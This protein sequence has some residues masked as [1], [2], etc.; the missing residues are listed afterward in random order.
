MDKKNFLFVSLDNLSGDLAWH[1]KKEGHEV[2][3]YVKCKTERDVASG[4]I[5]FVDD[6]KPHIDWADVII[7]DDVLGLG[8]IA[9]KLRKRGKKVVGGNAYTDRLEEDRSF[10]TEEM[11]RKGIKIIPYKDF[12]SFDDAIEFIKE[13]P[14]AYV[15]K[16]TGEYKPTALGILYIGYHPKGDDVIDVL[17]NT[18]SGKIKYLASSFKKRLKELR[19]L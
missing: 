1:I 5:D 15:L 7:F 18:K 16:P 2:K 12:S 11:Q 10:G 6:Y 3:Y 13:N 9:Q 14:C 17:E 19:L 4:F 8:K